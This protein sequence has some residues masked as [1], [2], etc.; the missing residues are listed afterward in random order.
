LGKLYQQSQPYPPGGTPVYT[1]YSYDA[2]G[3][4]KSVVL[5]DTIS[6]TTYAYQA[7]VV[8]VTDPAGKWK[9]FTMDSFGNLVS[10]QEPDPVLGTVTTS[11][12]YDVL[13]HLI[14]V[15]MPRGTSGTQTRTF[16]YN[17]GTTVTAFLQ[18]ATNPENGTVRYTYNSG[19]NTLATKTD[20]K[21]QQFSYAYDYYNRLTSVS[22]PGAQVLRTYYYDTNP[23]DNTGF[24]QNT[25]GR[26]AAVQY[27]PSGGTG[28]Q[29]NDMYGY[30][31]AG[32]PAAKRL[33]VSEPFTYLDQHNNQHQTAVSASL[34]SDYGYNSEG[35]MTSMS[36]PTT[37][38]INTPTPGPSYNYSYDSMYRLSGMTDSSNNTIVSNVGY[39]AANQLLTLDGPTGNETRGYNSLNQLT[40]LS[41]QLYASRELNLT[42]NYPTGTNNGKI[43]SMYDA[44][45][46]ETV[47]YTYDSLN[48][49]LTA[50]GS[51]SGTTTW[52][53]QYGFDG[54]GNLLS[55]TV[56]AGSG[57]SLSQAVSA[58][59]NQIVGQSYDANGNQY[60]NLQMSY[61]V[62]NRLNAIYLLRY[63]YDAQNKRIWSWAGDLD[64]NGNVTNYTVSVYSA[65]GQ[66]L[67][68]YVLAPILVSNGGTLVPSMQ[69]TLSS[70]DQYFGGRRLANLDRLGS[71]G[72][73]GISE[74][75]YFPWGEDKG[76]TSPQDTW[77]YA[78]YWRDS[79]SGLDY[80]NNRYYSNAGGRFVTSDP[81]GFKAGRPENPGSWN[82]YAYT[83]G[84]P[85]N[86][87]DPSG[88]DGYFGDLGVDWGYCDSVCLEQESFA[89][90]GTYAGPTAQQM[91]CQSLIL[92]FAQD[93]GAWNPGCG[94]PPTTGSLAS[95]P[96]CQDDW[97]N[98]DQTLG[99][100]L[101]IL[102][103]RGSKR[104]RAGT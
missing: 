83:A 80:A 23:L 26:L 98:V 62:E 85:V 96:P 35:K 79:V 87:N 30:T 28:V 2:S 99:A 97:G 53:Q 51:T 37:V 76:G 49:L 15:S 14:G 34:E 25:Q 20:A 45:S 71:A 104:N 92:S 94:A 58:A 59:N 101:S 100:C 88:L 57:P 24:S 46:G 21:N 95:P 70:G 69:V 3:R 74:G 89:E 19:S 6:T 10:V 55:K 68:A 52:G 36:Y 61:D 8:T 40:S 43:S 60:N 72:R 44:I 18:S 81:A 27:P 66:K 63:A 82:R 64:S 50:S 90:I 32:L 22:G 73:Q 65:S 86:G 77:N 48:R 75:K 41:V 103:L 1:T 38:S 102:Q 84:D 5:P 33:V 29:M 31:P 17:N 7:H 54:F 4:T 91:V 78:T 39:N 12:T 67:G 16:N 42:Y 56:T 9:T 11:Y 93:G 47:T 13:N